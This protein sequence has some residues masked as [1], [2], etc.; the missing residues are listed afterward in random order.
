MSSLFPVLINVTVANS[1]GNWDPV[2]KYVR[3]FEHSQAC[4][5]FRPVI[6]YPGNSLEDLNV[7]VACFTFVTSYNLNTQVT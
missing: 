6:Y 2:D 1:S 3:C 7:P 4:A 5:I